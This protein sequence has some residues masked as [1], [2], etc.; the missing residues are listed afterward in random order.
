[1]MGE[2]RCVEPARPDRKWRIGRQQLIG[3][4]CLLWTA[5]VI[6]LSHLLP[7]VI[8]FLRNLA[9]AQP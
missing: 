1:M 7:I 4:G 5:F 6:G 2:A 3:L 9:S 8:R